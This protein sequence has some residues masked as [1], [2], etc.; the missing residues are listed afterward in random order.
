MNT[1]PELL[2]IVTV[3]LR[4]VPE[5]ISIISWVKYLPH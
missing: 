1:I 4:K 5:T 3:C 2:V